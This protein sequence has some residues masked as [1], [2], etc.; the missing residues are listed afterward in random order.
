[1]VGDYQIKNASV[2]IAA[3]EE[4]GVAEDSIKNGVEKTGH[5][6]RIQVLSKKPLLI[7]DAAHN[8]EGVGNLVANLH[9]FDYENLSVVFS[10]KKNKD[11]KKMISLVAPHASFFTATEFGEE[12]ASAED[13]AKEA[14]FYTKSSFHDNPATA[15]EAAKGKGDAVLVCGSIYLLR[16]LHEEGKIEIK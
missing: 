5:P 8:P 6:G 15:F 3:A 16:R 9:L 1:M 4:I 12:S 10:A 7:V 14:G 2:A 11:W 13:L